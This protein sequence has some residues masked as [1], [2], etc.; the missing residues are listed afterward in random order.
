[1]NKEIVIECIDF[2]IDR[3]P[4]VYIVKVM[5]DIKEFVNGMDDFNYSKIRMFV[6]LQQPTKLGGVEN[7]EISSALGFLKDLLNCKKKQLKTKK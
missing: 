6:S 5:N 2:V 7:I 4:Q 1:M 3:R